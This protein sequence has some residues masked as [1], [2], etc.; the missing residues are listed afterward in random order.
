MNKEQFTPG[1][2]LLSAADFN[3][4]IKPADIKL[5]EAA[6]DMYEALEKA[7]KFIKDQHYRTS[8][9]VPVEMLDASWNILRTTSTIKQI[10]AAL[11]KANPQ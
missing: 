6:P 8:K 4:N 5:M 9:P 10:E 7:Y 2:W 11:N 1:P 3:Y